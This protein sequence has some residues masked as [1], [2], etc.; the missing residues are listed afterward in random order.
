MVTLYGASSNF[1]RGTSYGQTVPDGP[2]MVRAFT[3]ES[4][5][6]RS[7]VLQ[8]RMRVPRATM[9]LKLS[10]FTV[11][12]FETLQEAIDSLKGPKPVASA[13]GT[14]T[15]LRV[16]L[17]DEDARVALKTVIP[18]MGSGFNIS[19]AQGDMRIHGEDA[20]AMMDLLAQRLRDRRSQ[21]ATC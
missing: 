8:G 13:G 16:S 15:P 14:T 12:M 18:S 5:T 19:T 11:D 3:V 7:Y 4:T 9:L 21:L 20:K 1:Y 17:S 6:V 2:A 10:S